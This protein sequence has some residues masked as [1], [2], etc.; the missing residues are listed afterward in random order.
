MSLGQPRM[1]KKDDRPISY[2]DKFVQMNKRV[3]DSIERLLPQ[4]FTRS[5]LYRHELVAAE[6]MNARAGQIVVDIGGGHQAPFARHRQRDLNTFIA[7]V[8][9]LPS[10]VRGNSS[11]DA[12]V[13][14][15]VGKTIP[16][17][18]K[19]V[20]IFVTRSVIE[21]L[22]DNDGLFNEMARCLKK[23]G[24]SINVLP[25]CFSPFSIINRLLPPN[26]AK[27]LLYAL[28]PQW[29]DSCGFEPFYRNCYFPRLIELIKQ[30]GLSPE[31]VEYRYYQSIY[32][33][34]FVP[35]FIISLIYDLILWAFGI[36]LLAAQMLV[37]ARKD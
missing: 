25:C 14:A 33:K 29:R 20:D 30:S 37:V 16:F 15:D 35:F 27:R 4:Q 21:H 23:G 18:D 36:R 6:K 3:C 22:P 8:D 19:S 5:L 1:S 13:V 7:G 24:Y 32:F 2:F 26:I 12:G 11:I 34:F 17:Y 10:Q 31:Q 9:I 28:F